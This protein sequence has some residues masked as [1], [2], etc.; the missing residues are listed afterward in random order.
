[1]KILTF[2][3]IAMNRRII[4]FKRQKM[5]YLSF[6]KVYDRISISDQVAEPCD[7]CDRTEDLRALRFPLHADFYNR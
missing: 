2:M 3:N 4:Q 5:N 7:A 6:I 1:M